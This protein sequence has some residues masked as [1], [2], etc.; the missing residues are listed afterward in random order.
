[1]IFILL[2]VCNVSFS[3]AEQTE[4]KS[5]A[6]KQKTAVKKKV[7]KIKPSDVYPGD[8][9]VAGYIEDD[10]SVFGGTR[11][12]IIKNKSETYIYSEVEGPRPGDN[13][14]YFRVL[15]RY[16]YGREEKNERDHLIYARMTHIPACL[17]SSKTDCGTPP[18]KK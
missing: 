3:H 15:W 17:D 9:A 16:A 10:A 1:M 13:Y 7:L 2:F 5:S 18:L 6:Q 11:K 4:S 12:Y 14:G 8:A